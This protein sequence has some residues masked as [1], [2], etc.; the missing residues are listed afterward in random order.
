M[1]SNTAL[2]YLEEIWGGG[3]EGGRT[4]SA[5]HLECFFIGSFMHN[6]RLHQAGRRS[7]SYLC[8]T[9]YAARPTA[10]LMQLCNMCRAGQCSPLHIGGGVF[11]RAGA[12]GRSTTYFDILLLLWLFQPLDVMFHTG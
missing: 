1:L 8:I 12:R 10:Q 7:C 6:M 3:K 2:A 5:T 4:V 11:V 9:E